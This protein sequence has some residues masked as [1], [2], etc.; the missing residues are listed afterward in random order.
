M[1]PLR[2]PKLRLFRCRKLKCTYCRRFR[3]S[4]SDEH[5]HTYTHAYTITVPRTRY[6]PHDWNERRRW[7][8]NKSLLI[9]DVSRW[10][11]TNKNNNNKKTRNI[12]TIGQHSKPSPTRRRFF[13][14]RKHY[15]RRVRCSSDTVWRTT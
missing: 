14:T 4:T 6:S 8:L 5:I 11:P 12:L 13:S 7:A 1:R 9:Q 3:M 10:Y 2:T 15:T